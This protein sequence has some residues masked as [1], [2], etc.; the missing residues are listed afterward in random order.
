MGPVIHP[1]QQRQQVIFDLRTAQ[2]F[3]TIDGAD[4]DD[5]IMEL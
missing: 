4:V 5:L 3:P 1:A 2:Q